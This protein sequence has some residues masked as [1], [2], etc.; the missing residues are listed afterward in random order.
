MFNQ[1]H[2]EQNSNTGLFSDDNEVNILM[3]GL[4]PG[5][6]LDCDN[7]GVEI[8]LVLEV[9]EVKKSFGFPEEFSKMKIK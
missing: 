3:L 2:D 1:K 4:D 5:Y 6:A 8:Q 7:V 9:L